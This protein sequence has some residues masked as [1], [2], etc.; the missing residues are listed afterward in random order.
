MEAEPLPIPLQP[1]WKVIG[2]LKYHY[3]AYRFFPHK[4]QGEG[5]FLAIVRKAGEATARVLSRR[6]VR[7]EK[8]ATLPAALRDEAN[9]RLSHPEDFLI[10]RYGN[11]IR[12]FPLRHA[13]FYPYLCGQLYLLS[14]G[15]CLGEIKGNDLL[16]AHSLAMSRELNRDSFAAI[17]LSQEEAIQYLRK[18]TL[19]LLGEKG[20]ALVTYRG[21]PLGFVKR[22]GNRA[23]NLYP[24]E[25]RIRTSVTDGTTD[26]Q[27]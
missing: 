13:D 19:P 15:I 14:A 5:F 24:Q 16:P 10:E 25:W 22:L 1:E 6:N 7:M 27:P 26:R 20:Y 17:A 12:A 11:L 9:R 3:P 2:A 18:E 8:R 23:N 4:T 21:L